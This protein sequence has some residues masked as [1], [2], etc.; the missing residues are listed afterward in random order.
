MAGW[1][2]RKF[3]GTEYALIPEKSYRCSGARIVIDRWPR[4]LD[5]VL[6][7]LEFFLAIQQFLGRKAGELLSRTLN[8]ERVISL[9][10]FLATGA[11]DQN[12]KILEHDQERKKIEIVISDLLQIIS[13]RND[14]YSRRVFARQAMLSFCCVFTVTI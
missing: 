6:S 8:N 1:W 10:S 7:T 4:T 2:S 12:R 13:A 3:G 5:R 11:A 14:A 9:S